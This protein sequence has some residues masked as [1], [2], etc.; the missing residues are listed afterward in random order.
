MSEKWKG[1]EREECCE[2]KNVCG[3]KFEKIKNPEENLQKI[4]IM[5]NRDLTM[6]VTTI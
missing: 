4:L 5:S 1:Y 6:S 2:M 3:D